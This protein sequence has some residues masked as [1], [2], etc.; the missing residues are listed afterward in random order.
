MKVFKRIVCS[1]HNNIPI[2]IPSH[3]YVLLNRTVLYNCIIEAESNFLIESIAACDPEGDNVDLEMYF[4]A[5]TTFLNYFDELITTLDIP[6][7]YNITRQEHVLPISLESDYF[8]EELLSALKTLRELVEKYKQKKISFDKQHETLDKENENSSF[9]ETS[10]FDHLAF[11]F[12][13]FVMALILVIVMFIDLI[14]KGE[15][16]QTLVANLAMIR[17]VKTISKEI[18][19]IDKEYWIIIIWLSLILLCV[20]FLTIEKLYRMPMFRKYCY[21]NTIKIMLFISDIKSYVPIKL[22]KTSGSIHLFKLTSSINRENVTLHKNKLWDILEIDWRLVT[23]TLS[24]NVINLPGSV[25]IPFRDKFK[26][27]WIIKSKCLL[28][29][30]MLKQGQTWYPLSNIRDMMEI[31]NNVPQSVDMHI[32]P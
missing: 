7:F 28:L 10:F 14:F 9:I 21:S 29:H 16:M 32:E 17:G 31:E 18:K 20:L 6:F 15:K 2:E 27:R 30:L 22:C 26:I 5:N 13:I 4:M 25:I 11:N 19:A 3:P 8:D 23:I 1:T 24:G 12:F